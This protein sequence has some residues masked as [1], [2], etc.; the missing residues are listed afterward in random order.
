M[1]FIQNLEDLHFNWDL[2]INPWKL[3]ESTVPM[4]SN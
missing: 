4:G 2:N 3:R 1:N